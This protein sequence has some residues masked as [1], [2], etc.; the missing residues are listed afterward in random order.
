MRSPGQGLLIAIL[1]VM[2][3]VATVHEA[4]DIVA[5]GRRVPYH[6]RPEKL[7]A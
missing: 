4:V 2:D 3:E 1:C 6:R 7:S 5:E